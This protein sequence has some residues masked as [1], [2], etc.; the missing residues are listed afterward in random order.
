MDIGLEKSINNIL[1]NAEKEKYLLLGL[2]DYLLNNRFPTALESSN[3]TINAFCDIAKSM[4]VIIEPDESIQQIVELYTKKIS[5]LESTLNEKEL[6]EEVLLG[7]FFIEDAQKVFSLIEPALQEQNNNLINTLKRN[8]LE[9]TKQR[10]KIQEL[11]KRKAYLEGY[12]ENAIWKKGKKYKTAKTELEEINEQI[13]QVKTISS[14]NSNKSEQDI[15][16]DNQSTVQQS[17]KQMSKDSVENTEIEET[18]TNYD[19]S[20]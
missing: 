14:N 4:G 8:M 13:E 19:G 20:R 18:Q 2:I 9:A 17:T 15:E 10:E 11:E 3:R 12:L 5:E 6:T 16:N 1:E 7:E